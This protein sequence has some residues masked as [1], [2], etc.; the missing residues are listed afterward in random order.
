MCSTSDL[1]FCF[2][3]CANCR[4]QRG[5]ITKESNRFCHLTAILIQYPSIYFYLGDLLGIPLFTLTYRVVNKSPAIIYILSLP[6]YLYYISSSLVFTPQ[7]L[8]FLPQL[9]EFFPKNFQVHKASREVAW[10][11]YPFSKNMEYPRWW[12]I[13][14]VLTIAVFPVSIP[15]V[16]LIECFI[17]CYGTNPTALTKGLVWGEILL[18][19][20]N[21]IGLVLLLISKSLL[22]NSY[23]TITEHHKWQSQKQMTTNATSS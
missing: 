4:L 18:W 3:N 10:A 16:I 7:P 23:S 1:K 2:L 21:V 9:N 12:R 8:H 15:G 6:L 11:L 5:N 14:L 13:A 22:K 19:L 17:A 20:Q